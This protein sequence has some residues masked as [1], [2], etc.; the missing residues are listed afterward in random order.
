MSRELGNILNLVDKEAAK[1]NDAYISTEL[2]PLAALQENGALARILSKAGVVSGS[3]K[4]SMTLFV[5]ER[6][7]IIQM[8]KILETL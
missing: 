2:F 8:R 7:W 4:A 3:L 5:A 6:L 1:R